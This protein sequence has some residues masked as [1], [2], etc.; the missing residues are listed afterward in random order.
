MVEVMIRRC[1]GCKDEIP[2]GRLYFQVQAT[3]TGRGNSH[4]RA[5]TVDDRDFCS[6][7]CV[8]EAVRKTV[9]RVIGKEASDG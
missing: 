9:D 4:D 7:K 5:S 8:F 1:D 2:D 6:P 3:V